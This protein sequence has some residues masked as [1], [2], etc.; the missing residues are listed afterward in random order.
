VGL[1]FAA[2]RSQPKF[3]RD[4]QKTSPP[5]QPCNMIGTPVQHSTHFLIHL[6]P[7]TKSYSK[8]DSSHTKHRK[9]QKKLQPETRL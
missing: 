4:S 9:L 6:T 3:P 5:P 2:L 8:N 7:N 1:G